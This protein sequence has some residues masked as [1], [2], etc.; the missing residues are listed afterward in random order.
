MRTAILGSCVTR[1]L[2]EGTNDVELV[3]YFART[4]V[5]SAVSAPLTAPISALKGPSAFRHRM[6]MADLRKT[7][8]SEIGELEFDQLIVDLIDERLPLLRYGN[9]IITQSWEFEEAQL[10]SALGMG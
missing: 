4:S 7:A 9:T 3:A 1:D 8:L 10:E 5:V 6:V 2:L